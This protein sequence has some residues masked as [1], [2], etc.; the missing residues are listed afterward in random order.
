MTGTLG[1]RT[2]S[3]ANTL[4]SLYYNRPLG[5]MNGLCVLVLISRGDDLLFWTL[6]TSTD[7]WCRCMEQLILV[8]TSME[9]L[10]LWVLA[11]TSN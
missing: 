3:I 1:T 2:T 5:E 4:D 6:D 8:L 9:I 11:L 10:G 7:L